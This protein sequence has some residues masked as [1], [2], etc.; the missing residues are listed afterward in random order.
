M[1]RPASETLATPRLVPLI[2]AESG[3]DI[4]PRAKA[5]SVVSYTGASL[6]RV[7]MASRTCSFSKMPR[8]T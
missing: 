4:T 2:E 6:H 7:N 5:E 1:W 8:T 3:F